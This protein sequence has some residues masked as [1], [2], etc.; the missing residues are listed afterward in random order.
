ME[1]RKNI[2]KTE[3][4]EPLEKGSVKKEP[5]P[6]T[7]D[8]KQALDDASKYY[9]AM[10][11]QVSEEKDPPAKSFLQEEKNDYYRRTAAQYPNIKQELR[12]ALGMASKM[13]GGSVRGTRGY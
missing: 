8:E 5:E 11:K 6:Y 7:D 2:E 10:Q 13:Y 3:V 1:S 4:F 9:A 12:K